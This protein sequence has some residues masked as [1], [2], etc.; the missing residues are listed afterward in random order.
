MGVDS[1]QALGDYVILGACNP[2]L[3][4]RALVAGPEMGVLLPC[5]VVVRRGPNASETIVQ[6]IDPM[7]MVQLSVSPAIREVATDADS[8]LRA[9]L[10]SLESA[11]AGSE[12][13]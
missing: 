10:N 1:A 2:L 5:N 12:G 8:R 6:A 7:T 3:A 13:M 4:Q 9:A 11:T